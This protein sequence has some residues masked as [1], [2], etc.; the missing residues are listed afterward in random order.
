MRPVILHLKMSEL[1]FIN[2]LHIRINLQRWKRIRFQLFNIFE[3][4]N[5]I[6]VYMHIRHHVDQLPPAE[7]CDLRDHASQQGIT[8]N[9]ER[10][11]ETHVAA[12]L[13]E[14]AA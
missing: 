2:L 14:D 9:I 10:H 5:V 11:P 4:L 1:K 13:V 8:G 3:A 6:L 7:T 12:A